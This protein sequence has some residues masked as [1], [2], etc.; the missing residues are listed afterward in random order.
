MQEAIVLSINFALA[1][2]LASLGFRLL[3]FLIEKL[4]L[5]RW[6]W[7][8]GGKRMDCSERKKME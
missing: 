4:G 2:L 8:W 1:V 6:F 5:F 7:V 3:S